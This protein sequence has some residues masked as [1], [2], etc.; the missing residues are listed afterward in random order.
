M[1]EHG[2]QQNPKKK[3]Q[4]KSSYSWRPGMETSGVAGNR[5]P[6]TAKADEGYCNEATQSRPLT[7]SQSHQAQ[8]A[9]EHA[10][11]KHRRV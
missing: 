9:V 2:N 7:H 11:V 1:K 8:N 6:S 5:K 10:E 4:M 3:T